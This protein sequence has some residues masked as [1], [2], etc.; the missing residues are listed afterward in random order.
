MHFWSISFLERWILESSQSSTFT[1]PYFTA[2][3]CDSISSLLVSFDGWK[4]NS[5][6]GAMLSTD[7][8]CSHVSISI[9]PH[10]TV[11][12][13]VFSS[14]LHVSFDGWKITSS[15]TTMLPTDSSSNLSVFLM[16]D[17]SPSS[18]FTL[19]SYDGSMSLRPSIFLLVFLNLKMD[20][21]VLPA[22]T[23][24]PWD[25]PS[26]FL[27]WSAWVRSPIR[28]SDWLRRST[29]SIQHFAQLLLSVIVSI[30][31]VGSVCLPSRT[32]S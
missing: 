32:R 23:N 27:V 15:L 11:N 29:C 28:E 26:E 18:S 10:F 13:F 5:S 19:V 31:S 3:D 2:V 25:K 21:A 30:E 7:F 22:I 16:L 4:I 8:S 12:K 20:R 9:L 6:L 17:S 24:D 14:S 1:P